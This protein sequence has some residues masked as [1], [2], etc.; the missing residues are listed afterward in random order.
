[1][2]YA[3]PPCGFS[4]PRFLMCLLLSLAMTG[5][6]VGQTSEF[7]YSDV[8]I[9]RRLELRPRGR[10]VTA[11]EAA[12][13]KLLSALRKLK[14]RA[15]TGEDGAIREIQFSEID[16]DVIPEEGMRHFRK[17]TSLRC[18]SI[19]APRLRRQLLPELA[20][21]PMLEELSL[22]VERPSADTIRSFSKA[23]RLRRLGL[24]DARV[25]REVA[26][27]LA[28]LPDLTCLHLDGCRFPD[29]ID[30][31]FVAMPRVK[32][33]WISGG[34]PDKPCGLRC[35]ESFPGLECLWITS[36]WCNQEAM[37]R[38]GGLTNLE[39][40][41]L[42]YV[43]LND[44]S[45]RE[46]RPLTKL[47]RVILGNNTDFTGSGLRSV[48]AWRAL[49]ELSVFSTPFEDDAVN[50]LSQFP[51][52]QKFAAERTPLTD[53]SVDVLAKLNR[54]KLAWLSHTNITPTA[55]DRLKKAL[56]D[57]EIR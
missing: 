15:V 6:S 29:G 35:L 38:I 1:M 21:L 4:I 9:S 19:R 31:T 37:R 8:S 52:L 45:L 53:A 7:S 40:L 39:E 14:A 2:K 25:D 46:L 56:P 20:S 55:M 47:R 42:Q 23:P 28:E 49:E 16:S 48:N 11:E 33:L 22:D 32:S 17:L 41:S 5:H 43:G 34:G 12:G 54:L 30:T 57:C 51:E 27:A 24:D 44:D 13:N 18:L 36:I 26:A 10:E 50:L 3:A